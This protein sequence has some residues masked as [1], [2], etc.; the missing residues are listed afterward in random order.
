MPH[1]EE[2]RKAMDGMDNSLQIRAAFYYCFHSKSKPSNSISQKNYWENHT[3][4]V[5]PYV[6]VVWSRKTNSKNVYFC[7]AIAITPKCIIMPR[8]SKIK[9]DPSLSLQENAEKNQVTYDAI[10]YYV[11]TRGIDREGERRANVLAKIRE[12]KEANPGVSKAKLAQLAG[13]SVKT[14]TKYLPAVDGEGEVV[15]KKPRKEARPLVWEENIPEP[16]K[17]KHKLMSKR[18]AGLFSLFQDADERD[19]KGLHD[20]LFNEPEKPILLIG[21]GGMLDHF[22]AFLYEMNCGVARCITPLELA[23]MSDATIKSCKCLLLSSGGG[24]LDMKYATQKLLSINPDNTACYAN[25]IRENSSF[26]GIDP[27]RVFLFE[28]KFDKSFVSV[29]NKFFRDAIMYR[30]FTGNKASDIRIDT[31]AYYQYR[32][33]KSAAKLT[34]LRKIKHFAVLFSDYSAPAAHD[35]ESVLV[36]TGVA[37]AQVSD[38]RNYC[39]GRFLFVGNH[40]RHSSKKNTLTESEVAVVLFVSPLNKDLV[41]SIRDMAL[42]KET[43][44][45]LIETQYTDARATLDYLVK[46]NVFLADFEEKGLGINPCDPENYIAKEIDKRVPKHKVK[47]DKELSKNGPLRYKTADE[48]VKL[49]AA[50]SFLEEKEKKNADNLQPYPAPSIETLTRWEEYDASKYLCYAFR[51]KPDKRKGKDWVPFG[52]M[53]SG[54]DFDIQGVPFHNSEAAYICGMFSEDKQ[55]Q[56]AVQQQLVENTNGKIAK[57][58]IRFHNQGIARKDWYSFNIQ[59]MLYVVWQKVCN[60]KDFRDLLLAVPEGATIIEDTTLQKVHKPNDTPSFWGARNQ[61]RKEYYS[62]VEKYVK[63]TELSTAKAPKKRMIIEAYNNFTDYGIFKGCN[64]MGKILTICRSCWANGTEPPID[65]QALRQRNIHLL[66]KKLVFPQEQ[67]KAEDHFLLGTIAGDMIGKPYER[68]KNSIKTT[69]FPLFS[70]TSKYTDDTVLTIAV[71]DWLMT[72]KNLTWDRLA[73][74]FVYFGT[75]YRFKYQDRC[76]SNDFT[77]WLKDENRPFGRVSSS[78]GAAMRVSPVGWF[79]NSIDDVENAAEIQAK[80]THNHPDAILGAKAAAVAVLLARTRKNKKEIMDVMRERYGYDLS[81]PIDTYRDEH[82]WTSDCKETVKAALISFLCSDDFESAIRNAISLGGDSDTIGAI[83]G[84][85]AEAFYGGVPEH[86][87][88]EVLRRSIPDEFKEVM[89][90]F[91]EITR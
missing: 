21:N 4:R 33:N 87:K 64:V 82:L 65:Y 44:I 56:Y 61:E 54:F 43:P 5:L 34:P 84:S 39:H 23:S 86:I 45:V 22:S 40:T 35:F 10:R 20:F 88:K 32:L 57:G 31:S 49:D 46:A 24:N 76:F 73:D 14:I 89:E 51:Q 27:S 63:L 78:N 59:W 9:Y 48:I 81:L 83:T 19:V 71:M 66:G 18:M 55:D 80:L 17:Q 26:K 75:K 12:V 68:H 38:Y 52:N 1:R 2:T 36:E 53:N 30:A 37:S 7:V 74:R 79:F 50:I 25:H 42:A 70:K 13:V 28:A 90:R 16:A 11:K 77:A 62:L 72:D 69:D 91:A 47:F 85:I 29:E 15:F 8:K 6:K 41:N 67:I 60:N 3:R 58:D